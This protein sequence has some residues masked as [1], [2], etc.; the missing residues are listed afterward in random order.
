MSA[1][2]QEHKGLGMIYVT[3]I[4]HNTFTVHI[5]VGKEEAGF[6]RSN[7]FVLAE[8]FIDPLGIKDQ[9]QIP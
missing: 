5:F 6:E 9:T 7:R 2:M 1:R 3:L 8:Q 4:K